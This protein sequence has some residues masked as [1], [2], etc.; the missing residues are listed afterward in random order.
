QV[1]HLS[2]VAAIDRAR[3]PD[4]QIAQTVDEIARG[5]QGD[6]LA[7]AAVQQRAHVVNLLDFARREI[8]NHGAP[9]SFAAYDAHRIEAFECS[10]NDMPGA[11]KTS[12]EVVFNQ[13]FARSEPAEDN[14]LFDFPDRLDE[15]IFPA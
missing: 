9:V 2:Q 13:S 11:A 5:G 7:S 4:L 10:S 15:G 3:V 14:F 6:K 1:V 12:D 8:A